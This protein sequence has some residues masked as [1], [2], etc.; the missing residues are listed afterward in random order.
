M[1]EFP[2][3]GG[4]WH[5]KEAALLR[6]WASCIGQL[7]TSR[8]VSIRVKE[9]VTGLKTI[10]PDKFKTHHLVR[11]VQ[12]AVMNFIHYRLIYLPMTYDVIGTINTTCVIEVQIFLTVNLH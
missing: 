4:C 7:R 2:C 12:R 10:L 6:P 1:T 9:S 5:D 8:V 3:H 11:F